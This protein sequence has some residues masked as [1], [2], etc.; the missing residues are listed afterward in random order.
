MYRLAGST[1]YCTDRKGLW[2]LLGI[3]VIAFGKTLT[4]V[5]LRIFHQT[6]FVPY[7]FYN[8]HLAIKPRGAT[9]DQRNIRRQTHPI[10]MSSRF[11]IIEGVENDVEFAK[12]LNV[13]LAIFDVRMMRFEFC[14]RLEF[15]RY[16]LRNLYI[17]ARRIRFSLVAKT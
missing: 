4:T 10:N 15:A 14:R 9:F 3:A 13:E 12:P 11:K 7:L 2:D 17:G 6:A 16:F 1:P 5:S 8:L